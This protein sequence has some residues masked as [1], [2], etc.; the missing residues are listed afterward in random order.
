MYLS[1]SHE[2]RQSDKDYL[3]ILLIIGYKIIIKYFWK[4]VVRLREN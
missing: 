3:R 1:D 2:D 4:K